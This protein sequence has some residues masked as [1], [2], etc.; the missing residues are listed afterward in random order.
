MV[1]NENIYKNDIYY[2]KSIKNVD[3]LSE[4]NLEIQYIPKLYTRINLFRGYSKERKLTESVIYSE[5]SDLNNL[6]F[7]KQQCYYQ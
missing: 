1:V 5:F 2:K 3:N 7:F 4:S 6:I